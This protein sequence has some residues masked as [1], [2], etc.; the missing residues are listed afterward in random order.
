MDNEDGYLIPYD[1]AKIPE[2]E[3]RKAE[4]A[5]QRAANSAAAVER[6]ADPTA[7]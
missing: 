1:P 7:G 5:A 2:I 3:R 6:G 4:K